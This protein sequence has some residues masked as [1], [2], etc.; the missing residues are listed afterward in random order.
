MTHAILIV[1][2]LAAGM[3][4]WFVGLFILFRW[5]ANLIDWCEYSKRTKY[6]NPTLFRTTMRRY[7]YT[8]V[9][10]LVLVGRL[11]WVGHIIMA[12]GADKI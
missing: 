10:Y 7:L 4:L 3:V 11:F 12:M 2:Q 8:H 9:F 5:F 6:M 1:L